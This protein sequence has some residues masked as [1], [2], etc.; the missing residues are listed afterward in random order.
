MKKIV[1]QKTFREKGKKTNVKGLGDQSKEA[2]AL[3]EDDTRC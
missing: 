1:K 3:R 2:I